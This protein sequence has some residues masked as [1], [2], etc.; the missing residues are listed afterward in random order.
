MKIIINENQ[1]KKLLETVTND[2]EKKFIGKQVMVY[3]NLHKDTFQYNINQK[4]F[5]IPTMLN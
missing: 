4:L 1:Y 3:R 2:E 5:Y